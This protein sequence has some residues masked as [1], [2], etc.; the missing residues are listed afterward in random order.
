MKTTI[1]LCFALLCLSV[2]EPKAQA[3]I[4]APDGGYPGGNTAE[5]Q[6][7]LLSRTIGNYNTAVGFFSLKALTFAEFNTGVGAGTLFFNNAHQNTATGA[8]ALLNNVT[9]HSNTANGAFALFNNTSGDSNIALGNS[10]GLLLTT[11]NFNIDIGNPGLAGESSTI[12]IGNNQQ[13]RTF[14]TGIR[15]VMRSRSAARPTRARCGRSSSAWRGHEPAD[16]KSRG[17][18][19]AHHA[20]R[21]A[22]GARTVAVYSDADRDA[23]HVREADAAVR[24]G[25]AAPRESY[26][27]GA[28]IMAA[29][30]Q[31][32][33]DAVH[34]G[35]GFLAE[36]AG[37][38]QAVLDAGLV[39]VGPPPAAS[40]RWATRPARSAS[41]A[42]RR[43]DGPGDEPRQDDAALIAAGSA[44]GFPLMIKAAAGGGGRGMRLVRP[45]GSPPRSTRRARRRST[46][47]GDDRLL[48]ERS[49]MGARH[50]EVQVFA[51]GTATCC[52]SASATA[53]CSAGTRSSSRR[54]PSPAVDAA[55]R[56]RIGR[57]RSRSRRRRATW[58][59]ARSSSC[60][61][62]TASSISWR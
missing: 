9:G 20:Y 16:R 37:F 35:Y 22:H 6:N 31:T 45:G 27:N 41:R 29:A 8:G 30:R 49:L 36:N 43:A 10:A 23:L 34:P 40:A 19:A 59:P 56:E 62:T 52:I 51:D 55:L 18:R 58:A 21:A 1:R 2:A 7:A 3:V 48:L 33:A 25:G 12:R 47:F 24:I 11:G 44:V 61:T 39:W 28:A 54:A 50:I 42:R 17:D 14:I 13:T 53:R 46:P 57:P 26:L 15:G 38:A 4:P 32:G 60:S 5:G